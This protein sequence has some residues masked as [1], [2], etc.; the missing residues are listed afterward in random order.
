MTP[1][2]EKYLAKCGKLEMKYRKWIQDTKERIKE[3]KERLTIECDVE[4]E[5][6]IIRSH[7]VYLG[8]YKHELNRLKGMDRVVVPKVNF[9]VPQIREWGRTGR[10]SY[11]ATCKC[12]N[13]NLYSGSDERYCPNCGRLILWEKVK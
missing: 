9:S 6:S 4:W 12:G 8:W 13:G 11:Y 10:K 3:A 1:K 2:R 7:K 5:K